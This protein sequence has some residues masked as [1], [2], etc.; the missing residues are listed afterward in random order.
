MIAPVMGAPEVSVTAPSVDPARRGV[1]TPG[2]SA[3]DAG[4][5]WVNRVGRD[6]DV[7]SGGESATSVEVGEVGSAGQPE[8]RL[9]SG[10]WL[11]DR[12]LLRPTPTNVTINAR[13]AIGKIRLYVHES[14]GNGASGGTRGGKPCWVGTDTGT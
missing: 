11:W 9:G 12:H 4:V 7:V 13:S 14:Q 2:E 5:D 1:D 8:I 6:G 10:G 3:V